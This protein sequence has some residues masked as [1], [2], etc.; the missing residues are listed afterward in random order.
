[1]SSLLCYWKCIVP[2]VHALEISM[3]KLQCIHANLSRLAAIK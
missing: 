2:F 3:M 1:M